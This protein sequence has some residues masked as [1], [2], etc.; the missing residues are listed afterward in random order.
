MDF[1]ALSTALTYTSNP[2]TS[3]FWKQTSQSDFERAIVLNR[4][5]CPKCL[6]I[7]IS[8]DY[9]NRLLIPNEMAWVLDQG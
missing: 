7:Q 1:R 6:Q 4:F 2:N 9:R 8:K 3:V 5:T